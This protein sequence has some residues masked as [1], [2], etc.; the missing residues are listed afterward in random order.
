MEEKLCF[1]EDCYERYSAPIIEH[2]RSA[3]DEAAKRIKVKFLRAFK[4]RNRS[5]RI[6]FLFQI[7]WP[8]EYSSSYA[9]IFS[10]KKLPPALERF[11]AAHGE[12]ST[13]PI[14]LVRE[15]GMLL[16]HFVPVSLDYMIQRALD[17]SAGCVYLS[18]SAREVRQIADLAGESE[19]VERNEIL[20][21]MSHEIPLFANIRLETLLKVRRQDGDAFVAYRA[22]L[23]QAASEASRKGMTP[24]QSRQIYSDVIQPKLSA[25]ERKYDV[26]RRRSKSDLVISY[27]MPAAI[28]AMGV[29]CGPSHGIGSLLEVAGGWELVKNLARQLQPIQQAAASL[30][31]IRIDPM[32]FLLKMKKAHARDCSA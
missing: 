9:P 27:A 11:I 2:A 31:P 15:T 32:Y 13:L 8:K 19:N 6:L 16:S 7:K 5:N 30:D 18:D 12:E 20:A 3:A 22:A 1:C 21:S 28:L 25:L 17:A 23:D 29:I 24:A 4:E 14:D 10:L 26:I